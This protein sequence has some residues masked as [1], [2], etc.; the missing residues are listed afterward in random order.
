MTTAGERA[1]GGS[2]EPDGE[3]IA[4]G[5]Y[6][7]GAGHATRMLAVAEA[8][9]DRGYDFEIAGGGPGEPFV[10]ANGYTERPLPEV[11]FVGGY[12]SDN[13]SH[14]VFDGL[15]NFIRRVRAY[16]AWLNEVEPPVFL[17]DD[18][19]G[20]FAASVARQRYVY[21]SHDPA[22]FYD[23][24]PERASAW[25]RNRIPA[26]TAESFCFPKAWEGDPWIETATPVGPIAPA[27]D[28]PEAD[29]PDVDVLV[30]PSAFSVDEDDLD[31][32]LADAGRTATIVGGEDWTLKPSLQPYVRAADLVV[33]SG[34][35]TVMEAAVAGTACVVMPATSEQRGVAAAMEGT[36]GFATAETIEEVVALL[37]TLDAP[38]PQANGAEEIADAVVDAIET[39]R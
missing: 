15:P 5:H 2:D 30:V 17:T 7:E 33:C 36:R 31:A 3:P 22:A 1:S 4:V 29:L 25:I 37:G 32:A 8:L 6:C 12:Q 21:V 34:Y 18:I 24:P 23:S 16:V 27:D 9:A 20:C 10:E 13:G 19:C 38:E 39:A 28:T 14:V 26:V 11:D 35:S